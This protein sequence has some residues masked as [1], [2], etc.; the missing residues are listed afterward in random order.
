MPGEMATPVTT[1]YPNEATIIQNKLRMLERRFRDRD[2]RWEEVRA[3]RRGDFE[4]FP[5]LV[6]DAFPKPIVQNFIDTTARDLA[7]ML[8]PLPSFNCS[9]ISMRSDAERKRADMRTKIANN[10]I[11]NSRMN[12][13]L[14]YGADHYWTYGMTVFYVEPDFTERLPRIVVEDPSNGY[15]EFDRWDRLL[16]YTKKFYCD[17]HVLAD[18]YPEYAGRILAVASENAGTESEFQLE[19]IRYWDD[20][21]QTLTLGGKHP[22]VL[23]RLKNRTKRIPVVIAKRPWLD[24][25]IIKGQFDDVVWIQLARDMMAK[26]QFEAVEKAVQAIRIHLRANTVR[27]SPYRTT[28][29]MSATVLTR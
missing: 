24:T 3:I 11:T 8:A 5:D 17:A 21:G 23:Q 20:W 22:F 28:F 27:L 26:L 14:L 7:E 18:L 25:A 16:T 1:G 4:S 6:S 9:S 2:Q 10:Y 29:K 12:V 19:L 13:Q 15:P